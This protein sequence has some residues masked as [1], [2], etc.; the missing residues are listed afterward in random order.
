[1]RRLVLGAVWVTQRIARRI[2]HNLSEGRI[3]ARRRDVRTRCGD[4]GGFITN[5]CHAASERCRHRL[6]RAGAVD[7]S[8]VY[9]SE[10][11][12]QNK[13]VATGT[14]TATYHRRPTGTATTTSNHRRLTQIPAAIGIDRRVNGKG[15]TAGCLDGRILIHRIRGTTTLLSGPLLL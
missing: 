14:T 13:P 3:G 12:V 8:G 10:I 2:T 9:F 7:G 15:N 11:I 4:L 6:C 1:M 5:G